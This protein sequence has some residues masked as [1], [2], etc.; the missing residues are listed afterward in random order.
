M[1]LGYLCSSSMLLCVDMLKLGKMIK[2]FQQ[3]RQISE[4]SLV[5][6]IA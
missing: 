4:L 1:K 6:I 2:N 3:H 5:K